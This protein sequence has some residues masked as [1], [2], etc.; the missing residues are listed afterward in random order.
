MQAQELGISNMS[1]TGNEWCKLGT[2]FSP[3]GPTSRGKH[4]VGRKDVWQWFVKH[5]LLLLFV[6]C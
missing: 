5:F 2:N 3:S 1:A 6:T 4:M